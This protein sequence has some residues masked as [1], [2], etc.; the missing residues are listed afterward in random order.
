MAASP[1][2]WGPEGSE[3]QTS[4]FLSFLLLSPPCPK[5][6]K[7]VLGAGGGLAGG[8][9][10]LA[11]SQWAHPSIGFCLCPCRVSVAELQTHP[12]LDTDGDGALSEGEAQVPNRPLHLGLLE[13]IAPGGPQGQGAQDRLAVGSSRGWFPAGPRPGLLGCP[14][15]PTRPGQGRH[16]GPLLPALWDLVG[17]HRFPGCLIGTEPGSAHACPTCFAYPAKCTYLIHLPHGWACSSLSLLVWSPVRR[18]PAGPHCAPLPLCLCLRG[19]GH[20]WCP[21]LS[22]SLPGLSSPHPT[23]LWPRSFPTGLC[24]PLLAA[25]P[26]PAWPRPGHGRSGRAV[27]GTTA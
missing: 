9:R 15:W 11:S 13:G 17:S 16:P 7:Q 1:G 5:V 22:V 8:G 2:G 20:L 27:P 12:E 10:Q 26:H 19:P 3:P 23:P 18:C 25:A 24:C 21:C 6:L 14:P 4:S